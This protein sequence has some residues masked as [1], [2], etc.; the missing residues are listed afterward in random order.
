MDNLFTRKLQLAFE[1]IRNPKNGKPYTDADV[2]NSIGDKTNPSH[3]SKLRRGEIENPRYSLVRG[4]AKCFNLPVSFFFDEEEIDPETLHL[5]KI[6]R[7]QP[8]L[9]AIALRATSENVDATTE[10]KVLLRVIDAIIESNK[11][12]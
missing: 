7:Q 3:I 5:A 1:Q 12:G 6:L 9:K 4:I 10:M 2:A 11:K 8:T